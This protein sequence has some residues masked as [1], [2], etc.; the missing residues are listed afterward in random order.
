MSDQLPLGEIVHH[1]LDF[2]GRTPAKLGMEW[3]GGNIQALS[4]NNVRDGWIDFQKEC[5]LG[6]EDL[7][8]AW[9][10]R[11][12]CEKGD[13]VFTM[14]APM[15]N[16]AQIP[17]DKKYILSQRVVLLSPK[18]D[19][20]NENYLYHFMRSNGFRSQSEELAT[21]TTAK[22]IK[23]ANLVLLHISLPPLPEQKKIAEILSGIDYAI[24][25]IRSKVQKL[26]A[27][28]FSLTEAFTQDLNRNLEPSELENCA[29]VRT[30]VAKNS[31]REGDM[32]EMPYMRVANVQDG[33]L[34][35]GEIKSISIDRE[36]I[37]RYL[38][39]EGDVLINE[40]GDLD[41][42]GRGVIWQEEVKQCLHQNHV[43]A[44]RCS[45]RLMPEFLSLY[46]K[47]SHSKN[48]FLGCAK[49]T[50]NLA[51]INSAQLK[52]FPIP[53]PTLGEQKEFIEHI[54]SVKD[55]SLATCAEL[56][57]LEVLKKAVSSDLLSGLKR[58]SV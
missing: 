39:Q 35:L 57:A 42:V 19:L 47:S 1:I 33:Y 22:G 29:E 28:L 7:Y 44:V 31:N 56:S 2:R 51:S 49:Q 34:D 8:A 48:Y 14:E 55:L 6:G 24:T 17:D 43:F 12:D 46:L 50:T 36:K 23:Q 54:R 11:G 30:G 32:V 13:I 41:K 9:M 3:G 21:G 40:G 53:V 16:V 37:D 27:L 26:D 15:G 5:N 58:V 4:A 18:K 45:E 20:V 25:K 38:L 10:T 52:S